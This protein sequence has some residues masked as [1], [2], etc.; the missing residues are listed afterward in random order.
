[1]RIMLEWLGLL[2]PP[3]GRREP[4][5]LPAWAPLAFWAAAALGIYALSLVVSVLG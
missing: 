2:E 3:P 5:A 1:M 4:V